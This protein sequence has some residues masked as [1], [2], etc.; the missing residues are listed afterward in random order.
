M[1]NI[2]ALENKKSVGRGALNILSSLKVADI[3]FFLVFK[4]FG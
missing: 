2:I 1:P 4:M 3:S